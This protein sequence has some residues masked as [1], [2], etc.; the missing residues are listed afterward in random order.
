[1]AAG[2][3]PRRLDGVLLSEAARCFG[4]RLHEKH[5][6]ALPNGRSDCNKAANGAMW[7]SGYAPVCKTVYSGSI[8]DVASI[9]LFND[10]D[11]KAEARREVI[12]GA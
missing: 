6:R 12:R 7:R 11:R 8:P 5:S 1:M 4:S 3:L 2:P 9:N 10:I